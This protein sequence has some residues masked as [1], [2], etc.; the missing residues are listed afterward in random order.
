[1]PCLWILK[2]LLALSNYV[3]SLSYRFAHG[4]YESLLLACNQGAGELMNPLDRSSF[5]KNFRATVADSHEHLSFLCFSHHLARTHLLLDKYSFNSSPL[6]H[7]W[8]RWGGEALPCKSTISALKGRWRL[9][10]RV[11]THCPPS[12]SAQLLSLPFIPH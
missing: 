10:R 3:R 5:M 8:D 11:H 4:G 9:N 2:T 6:W 1:M 7:K 12:L